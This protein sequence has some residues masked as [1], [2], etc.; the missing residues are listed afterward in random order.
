VR[1]HDVGMMLVMIVMILLVTAHL[2]AMAP[3]PH[4]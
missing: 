1:R 3:P 4:V 2:D